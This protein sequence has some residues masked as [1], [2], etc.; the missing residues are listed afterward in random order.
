MYIHVIFDPNQE[1]K[2]LGNKLVNNFKNLN[3]VITASSI[4]HDVIRRC[5]SKSN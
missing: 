4:N 5:A 1:E 3:G 2:V